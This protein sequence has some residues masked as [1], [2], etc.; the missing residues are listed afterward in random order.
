MEVDLATL[1]EWSQQLRYT[2]LWKTRTT[3][4]LRKIADEMDALIF[5]AASQAQNELKT[6]EVERGEKQC[7]E[8]KC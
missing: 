3:C 8:G 1:R 2:A 4:V 6:N 7:G 5:R